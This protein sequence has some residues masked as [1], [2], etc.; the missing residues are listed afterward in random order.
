MGILV[1]YSK[2]LFF[3]N[4]FFLN[5]SFCFSG[6]LLWEQWAKRTG[7]RQDQLGGLEW[8]E[9]LPEREGENFSGAKRKE[10]FKG[11]SQV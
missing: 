9:K 5:E 10:N 4:S 2:S 3:F 11:E 6:R 7:E 1:Q 8:E